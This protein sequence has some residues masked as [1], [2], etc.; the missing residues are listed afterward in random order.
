MNWWFCL[1]P[2]VALALDLWLGDPR[3]LPHTVCAVGKWAD[4]VEARVRRLA[5]KRVKSA[6]QEEKENVAEQE[7]AAQTESLRHQE[8]KEKIENT[9]K[10]ADGLH[11]GHSVLAL[12]AVL[13]PVTLLVWGTTALPY[14]GGL[15][16]LYFAYSGLAL[17]CLLHECRAAQLAI[18]SGTIEEARTAVGYLVSRNTGTLERDELR[19]TLAETLSEN[20]NDGFVAPFFYLMF[21]GAGLLWF[22]K[23]S[24]TLDSMWGYKNDKWR[25]F[26]WAAARLDDVLAYIPARIAALTLFLG[27][28]VLC[29]PKPCDHGELW[30][31]VMA[32]AKKME[33]PNA[34]YPMAMA[35]W[36]LKRGMG[37]MAI[38]HGKPKQKPILGIEGAPWTDADIDR[39]LKL[40]KLS[41]IIAAWV[42]FVIYGAVRLIVW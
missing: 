19:K 1:L 6:P 39:L 32:D 13:F 15:C 2:F 33:S 28:Q 36:L 23:A 12:C 9:G 34:G 10:T 22:Y 7:E 29:L 21:G 26:G 24:S 20:Y 3:A 40:V 42:V 27:A 8:D 37:G 18:T 25:V 14:I 16:A 30:R 17:G 41:G 11:R 31:N 35:A 5:L 4:F 38:Y